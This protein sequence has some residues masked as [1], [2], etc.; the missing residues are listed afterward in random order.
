MTKRESLEAAIKL[1]RNSFKLGYS[2]EDPESYMQTIILAAAAHLETLP[3]TKTVD[4]F[5][6][7]Y[8][9][10]TYQYTVTQLFDDEERAKYMATLNGSTALVHKIST[11]EWID[12][13]C[14]S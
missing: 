13:E 7:T 5:L 10:L 12:P 1:A 2:Q 11:V 14:R 8:W 9:S 3:R 6:L 4:R